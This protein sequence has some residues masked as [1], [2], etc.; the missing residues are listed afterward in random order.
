[1]V[2]DFPGKGRGLVAA[3]DIKMGDLLFK[4]KAA[5]KLRVVRDPNG[6]FAVNTVDEEFV[7]SLKDQIEN[8]PTE[9]KPLVFQLISWQGLRC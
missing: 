2:T 7:K 1:M 6:R 9:A 5:I 4:V 3:R 8:L